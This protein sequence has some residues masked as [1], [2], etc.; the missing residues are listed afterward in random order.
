MKDFYKGG[1]MRGGG[2]RGGGG[3]EGGEGGFE[4]VCDSCFSVVIFVGRREVSEEEK[5]IEEKEIINLSIS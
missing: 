5:D 2:R 3:R 4:V 1:G